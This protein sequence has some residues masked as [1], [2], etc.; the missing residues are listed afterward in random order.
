MQSYILG[1]ERN[2]KLSQD[3]IR[4]QAKRVILIKTFIILFSCPLLDTL[5]KTE[6][7]KQFDAV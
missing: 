6:P 4:I 7:K 3:I 1:R 2:F 5:P